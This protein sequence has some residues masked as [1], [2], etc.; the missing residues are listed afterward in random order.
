MMH[1]RE[2]SDLVIVAVK[3]A[4]KAKEAHCGGVCGGGRSGVGGAK[5]GGQGEYAPAKHVLD[6][7]PGSRDKGAGAYTATLPSHTRGR[8]RMR[9]SRTYGSGRGACDETHV[10]TA[11]TARVHHAARR[12]GGAWPLAASAQQRERVRRVGVFMPGTADDSEYQAGNGAFLQ[13]L[14]ELG[15]IVGRNVRIDYRWGAGDVDRY[16]ATAADLVSLAPDVMLAEGTA[17]VSALQKATRSVPIVFV[18]VVDP[19]GGSLVASLAQPGGN[20]TGFLSTEFGFSGKWLEL[21]KD[22]APRVR[23][24]AVIRDSAITSQIGMFGGI[25]SVAS[26]LGVELRPIDIRDTGEMERAVV[27]FAGAPNGGSDRDAKCA[28]TPFRVT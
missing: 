18:D 14:G 5:G 11:T 6:S 24:V 21:L 16:R 10:P 25:Q 17:T 12:R 26:S 19:V 22:I 4:N 20:A 1:G 9:E 23:R 7:E 8:S 27:E 3:P 2:K 15:W 13:A 28:I